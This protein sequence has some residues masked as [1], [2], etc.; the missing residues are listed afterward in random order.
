MTSFAPYLRMKMKTLANKPSSTQSV[1]TWTL[2][3]AM[4]IKGLRN[5]YGRNQD[6]RALLGGHC[7]A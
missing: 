3:N 6:C 5:I 4:I 2:C 7:L 1:P